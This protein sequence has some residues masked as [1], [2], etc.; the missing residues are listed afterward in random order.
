VAHEL[1]RRLGW[2][3]YDHE[4]LEQIAREMGLCVSLVESLDERRQSWMRECLEALSSAPV[5]S[6]ESYVHH[7]AETILSLGAH[8]HCIIVGRGAA[9]ILPPET[10]LRVRLIGSHHDRVE[11][12]MRRFGVSR[13][14][15]ERRLAEVERERTRFIKEHFLRDPTEPEQYDLLINFSRWSIGECA[16][17]IMSALEQ[18]ERKRG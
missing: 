7:L 5:A 16:E 11:H 18:L 13:A 17:L 8:G 4:L 1:G 14:E 15:A 12:F 6:E 9:Q 2:P 3:V 10:T